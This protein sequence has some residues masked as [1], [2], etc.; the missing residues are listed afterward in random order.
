MRE[1][2][3][4]RRTFRAAYGIRTLSR[5]EQQYDLRA[6]NNPS[7]WLGPVWGISNY[8]VFRGLARY[9]FDADA[10]AL[11]DETVALFGRD[12]ES[13][14]ALH[15]YYHPD[16]GE[17]IMTKGFQNWNFLVL[18]MMAWQEGRHVVAEL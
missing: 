2:L 5:L 6:S 12:L 15:E 16:T 3:V 14:G 10:A 4:D 1:R 18:N 17:P 9:G 7:N 8:L 11:V 13:S